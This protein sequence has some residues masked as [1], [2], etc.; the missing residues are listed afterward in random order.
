MF[1]RQRIAP[2]K[3]GWLPTMM[4]RFRFLR[5]FKILVLRGIVD[6]DGRARRGGLARR[7]AVVGLAGAVAGWGMLATGGWGYLRH[8]RGFQRVAWVDAAWPA[9]WPNLRRSMGEHYLQEGARA[10][11]QRDFS[12]ALWLYRAGVARVPGDR[13]GRLALAGLYVAH[14]R[15]DLAAELLT[16]G[17]AVLAGDPD[18][19]RPTLQFLFER[20]EDDRLAGLCRDLLVSAATPEAG[21]TRPMVAYFA[22]LVAFHHGD[23]DQTETLLREHRLLATAEGLVLLAETDWERGFPDLALARLAQLVD[24]T[25]AP[26]AAYALISRIHRARG[27][28]RDLE[29]NATRRLAHAPLAAEPRLDLLRLALERGDE[30]RLQAALAAYLSSFAREP[31]ALLAL[32]D[33]AAGAGRPEWIARLQSDFQARGWPAGPVQLLHAEAEIN[34]GDH[35]AALA[36]LDA[37]V[38]AGSA[39]RSD[40]LAPVADGLRAVALFGLGREDEGR[41]RLDHLLTRP[42]L[43]AANLAAVATRL[44]KL[45]RA[46]EARAVLARAVAIDPLNQSALTLLVRLEVRSQDAAALAEH[47]PRLLA[48]RRPAREVL[49]LAAREVGSDRHLLLPGQ[50]ALL[51]AMHSRLNE[52]W[53]PRPDAR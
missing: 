8:V 50:A 14:R 32:G 28:W 35:G 24:G 2:T 21:R 19:V 29:L 11:E 34:R 38:G 53:T 47:V 33:F 23:Y 26:D 1:C 10:V 9:R 44:L 46:A 4:T 12:R 52:P 39:E 25:D 15:S 45:D 3:S 49:V 31:A 30:A 20:Q 41:L 37:A 36:R 13:E 6:D 7:L 18:Y 22:A 42:N 51:A 27:A 48:M 17:V 16:S 43:R 40:P 5:T